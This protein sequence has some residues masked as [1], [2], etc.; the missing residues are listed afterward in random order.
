VEKLV[1]SN[2]SIDGFGGVP[3]FDEMAF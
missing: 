3:K 2:L 1:V